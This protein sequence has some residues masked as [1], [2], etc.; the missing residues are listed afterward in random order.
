M[1]IPAVVF[2]MTM[3]AATARRPAGGILNSFQKITF[4]HVEICET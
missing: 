1:S 4:G 3:K 2:I